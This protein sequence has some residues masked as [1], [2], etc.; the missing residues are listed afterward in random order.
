MGERRAATVVCV[1]GNARNNE[2]LMSALK[3]CIF[4][5]F[6]IDILHFE[7]IITTGCANL[8]NRQLEDV[9]HIGFGNIATTQFKYSLCD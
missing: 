6:N 8:R 7:A 2:I 4:S 3:V 9:S 5:L 1:V